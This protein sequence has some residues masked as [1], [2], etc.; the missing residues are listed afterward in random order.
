MWQ[1]GEMSTQTIPVDACSKMVESATRACQPLISVPPEPAN[2]TADSLAVLSTAFTFGSLLLGTIALA[3]AI[4]WGF[5]V[6]VWAEREARQEAERCTKNWLEEE[7]FPM[8]R[9]EMQEWKKTFPQETPIS[10]ID[11]DKLVAAAGS[12]GK[13]EG[14][15]KK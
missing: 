13:E 15:G 14:D 9:R 12:D 1:T 3:G 4:A 7:A 5:V 2:N 6:K 10:D 11:I 8:L